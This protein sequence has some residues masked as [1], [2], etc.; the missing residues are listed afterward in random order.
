MRQLE[1]RPQVPRQELRGECDL[2]GRVIE[3]A[4]QHPSFPRHPINSIGRLSPT[5]LGK[6]PDDIV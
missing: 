5:Q 4:K 6:V 2:I 1:R 3:L